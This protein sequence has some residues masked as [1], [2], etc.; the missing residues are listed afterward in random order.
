ANL[1]E[2]P[3]C[4]AGNFLN[5]AYAQLRQIETDLL[6]D[7]RRRS[8]SLDL[9]LDVTLDQR[10]HIDQ[11]YGIEINWWPAKI[12]ETA[13]FLVDHQA[14]R[15]LATALGQAPDRLPITI[16]ATIYQ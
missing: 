12:A 6:A 10:I 9:S 2:D 15:Q 7:Q 8:G 4:G 13:M 14:N 11:F 1:Y 3:A 16:T 5:V